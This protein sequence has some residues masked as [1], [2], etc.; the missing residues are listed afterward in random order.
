VTPRGHDPGL[1]YTRTAS[2][3]D[4]GKQR[5]LRPHG[6]FDEIGPHLGIAIEVIVALRLRKV[7]RH[8]DKPMVYFRDTD[9]SDFDAGAL[10]AAVREILS[11][12]PLQGLHDPF[13]DPVVIGV[14][15]PKREAW[16]LL[17]FEAETEDERAAHA[18]ARRKLG[19]CPVAQPERI[20]ATS[21]GSK[22]DIK[23]VLGSL[24]I[25]GE[26]HEREAR[27]LDSDRVH[28]ISDSS[29]DPTGVGR[30]LSD[31]R[32]KVLCS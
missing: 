3:A 12:N 22:R 24:I 29:P 26:R 32:Q 15:H 11:A 28:C 23:E 7:T 14:A 16:I 9:G 17:G 25:A 2:L 5:K 20:D 27:C 6:K 1:E 31:V 10:S 19:H 30:F 18:K 4:L 13:E 8:A 21:K